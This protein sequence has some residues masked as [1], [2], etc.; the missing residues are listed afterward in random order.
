M[1]NLPEGTRQWLLF[2]GFGIV[3]S[4]PL[5]LSISYIVRTF[6]YG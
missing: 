3:L 5:A 4:M 1:I 2:V 6:Q